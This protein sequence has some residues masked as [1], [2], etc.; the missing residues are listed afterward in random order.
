[1]KINDFGAMPQVETMPQVVVEPPMLANPNQ[2][3]DFE[4][5]KVQP[6]TLEQLMRTN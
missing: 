5:A 3:F 1:M 2:F 6:L 4:K